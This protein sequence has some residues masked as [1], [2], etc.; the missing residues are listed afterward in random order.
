MKK[1]LILGA[2]F[3][4]LLLPHASARALGGVLVTY[5]MD[6]DFYRPGESGELFLTL[7]NPTSYP[8]SEI[9]IT[10]E[11]GR[12]IT[13]EKRDFVLDSLPAGSVQEL[14][15]V[16]R[17]NS[18]AQ[19]T[20]SWVKVKLKYE[21]YSD[22]QMENKILIPVKIFREPVIKAF[23]SLPEMK[24]GKSEKVCFTLVNY[25]GEAKDVSISLNSTAFSFLPAERF[26]QSLSH[27]EKFCFE[28]KP[29][30]TLPGNY[31]IVL[32]V[33]YRDALYEHAYVKNFVYW[34][35]LSGRVELRVYAESFSADEG[36]LSVVFSNS[37]SEDI[38]ALYVRLDSALNLWPKEIYIGDLERDDYDSERIHLEKIP[39]RHRI[40]VTAV[41]RDSFEREYRKRF[42]LE[43]TIPEEEEK[44]EFGL[45]YIVLGLAI[46][47]F[48][49]ICLK[50]K[51]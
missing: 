4:L 17:I 46:V 6:R 33:A 50:L 1:S 21:D 26:E 22:T 40:N 9:E 5:T 10:L 23:T 44:E 28:A 27:A 19:P 3:L 49:G 25:G 24:I 31:P 51:K 13:L 37:G 39:G 32:T 12:Y 36:T 41:Y 42:T 47:L 29:L 15:V 2:F 38:K 45:T 20:I 30:L 34:V 43:V 7:S 35:N 11:G 18:S 48:A 8:V 14:G 16:F